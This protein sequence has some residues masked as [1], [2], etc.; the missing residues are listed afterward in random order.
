M[1]NP[2]SELFGYLQL[3]ELIAAAP[4]LLML[5]RVQLD[6]DAGQACAVKSVSMNEEFFLGHFPNAPIMP[7]VLQVAAMSQL[8]EALV[9][10][11]VGADMHICLE[12]I[13]RLKF[14]Q[15]VG[16]GDQLLIEVELQEQ[17][18]SFVGKAKVSVNGSATSG[19]EIV[20]RVCSK[21]EAVAAA[22]PTVLIEPQ[23]ASAAEIRDIAYIMAAIPHRYPFLLID[24][25][26]SM[27][28]SSITVLKNVTGN[29]PYM[30][31]IALAS[32]PGYLQVEMAAQAGC[33]LSLADP[34]NRDKLAYFMSIDEAVFHAPV[35]PGDQL[36]IQV[37]VNS[38]GRFGK[39]DCI[40]SVGERTVTEAK[41][42]FAIVDR[43]N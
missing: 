34:E 29:E 43:Q 10:R 2:M 27:D 4:P 22:T 30:R 11:R 40:L 36:R 35:L 20:L 6:A 24:R 38:K 23:P 16:P 7:G 41:I 14:R 8:S 32:V 12:Q 18:S 1:E 5:D 19:G 39:A 3:G 13:R 9:R 17:D 42:K 21:S 26:L 33:A 15:P 28:V 31:G 25:V 37:D